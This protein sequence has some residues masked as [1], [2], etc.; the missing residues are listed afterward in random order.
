MRMCL[1]V[2]VTGSPAAHLGAEKV[3]SPIAVEIGDLQCVTMYYLCFQQVLAVPVFGA[4][5]V[6]L[7]TVKHQ[8]A[9]GVSG[10]HHDLHTPVA[11]EIRRH[12]PRMALGGVYQHVCPSAFLI[13]EPSSA[14]ENLLTSI[15][16]NI[17]LRQTFASTLEDNVSLPLSST[18]FLRY[19]RPEQLARSLVPKDQLE[20]AVTVEVAEN[21]VVVLVSQSAFDKVAFPG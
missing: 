11:V 17:R 3:G 6:I 5:R 20:L 4:P 18:G 13:V 1:R 21:L 10:Y 9:V 19:G 7:K 2:I 15:S 8:P 12:N 14:S 16:V